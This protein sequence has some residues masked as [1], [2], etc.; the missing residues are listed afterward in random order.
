MRRLRIAG[1]ATAALCLLFLLVACDD[2]SG[3]ADADDDAAPDDDS[4]DD[5]GDDS[6]D[7]SGDDSGDDADD[8]LGDLFD[9]YTSP[10]ARGPYAVGVTTI[11]LVDES[12]FE[13]WG[14]RKRALPLEIW[15][16]S[17]GEGGRSNA[18]PDMV[19]ALPPWALPLFEGVYGDDFDSLWATTTTALRDAG[20]LSGHGRFPVILF[21]HGYMAIRFQN[22][23]LCEHLASHGFVVVAPDHYGNAIFT[24]LPPD[25]IVLINPLT[26][27]TSYTDRNEDVAFLFEKLG[28]MDGEPGGAWEGRL[29]LSKFAVTGHSYGGLTALLAGP[30]QPFVQAIAPLNPVWLGDF[31]RVFG[32]P[33]LLLQ[34]DQ[35]GVVGESNAVVKGIFEE[36]ASL[37]KLRV[38]MPRG[39][40]YSVTDACLLLPPSMRSP[41]TGC[42]GSMIDTALAN[43][44]SAAYVTAFFRAV[45]T[46]DARYVPYLA[47]NHW[48][49]DIELTTKWE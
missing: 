20:V 38:N 4:D 6:A 40:H 34:G 29:A 18:L 21:S 13:A 22:Y 41:I 31:P 27:A 3:G 15:Y 23:T 35:D 16:P 10:D 7:D 19:G 5:A 47:E 37:R 14:M 49:D 39:G 2:G 48:P 11:Y 44:I 42:D 8:D 30:S 43:T 17:T 46:D 12:R 9:A 33:F 32:K 25:A 24:N 26:A 36:S 1:P 45:L 28:E